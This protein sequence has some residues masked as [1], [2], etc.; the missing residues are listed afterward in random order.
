[1]KPIE[2]N[3][4]PLQVADDP[5]IFD[6]VHL[7]RYTLDSLDLER[8]IVGLFLTQ[9]P[10]TLA[11]IDQAASPQDWKLATHSLKGA[12]AA[13]GARRICRIAAELEAASVEDFGQRHRLGEELA[14]A[15]DEFRAFAGQIYA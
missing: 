2:K 9:L 3:D 13:V 12:A 14:A 6:R 10:E 4:L 11:M 15:A 8:E 5:E 1:M 7:A